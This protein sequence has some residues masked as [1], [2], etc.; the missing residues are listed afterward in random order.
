[1]SDGGAFLSSV[2]APAGLT[3]GPLASAIPQAGIDVPT[4][5]A[6]LGVSLADPA[7][8]GGRVLTARVTTLD[9]AE[10]GVGQ[11]T[12]PAGGWWVLG[13]GAGDLTNPRPPTDPPPVVDPPPSGGPT[14]PPPATPPSPVATPEPA[15][16]LL[17]LVGL[18]VVAARIV[19]RRKAGPAAAPGSRG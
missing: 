6:R 17:A 18:P 13:L 2:N 5:A 15:T 3:T 12:V 16:A 7:A 19:K 8:D 1:V 4:A 10:L 9:G 11:L 14:D